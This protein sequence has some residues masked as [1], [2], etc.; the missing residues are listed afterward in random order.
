MTSQIGLAA[1]V[2]LLGA[3]A[4]AAPDQ[5]I[6]SAGPPGPRP[7]SQV[8]GTGLITGTVVDASGAPI[9]AVVASIA[10]SNAPA[11]GPGPA[12]KMLTDNNGRFFFS[13]LA[14][15]SFTITATKPGWLPGAYGRVRPGGG[16]VPI[17]LPDGGRRADIRITMW[18]AA[19]ISGRVID[20]AGDPLIGAEIRAVPQIFVAGRRQSGVP[21]RGKADDRGMYRFAG[22]MPGS[23]IV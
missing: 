16:S 1:G 5:Q 18:P 7:A 12:P 4:L 15:G 11:R 13:D 20:D 17:D 22:L 9:P 19:T 23:Y 6:V 8:R 14:A 10:G 3:M 2:V 21:I